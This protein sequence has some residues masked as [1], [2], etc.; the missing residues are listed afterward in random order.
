MIGK[1]LLQNADGQTFFLHN[2]ILAL[3]LLLHLKTHQL[4]LILQ[5]V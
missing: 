2:N 5:V 1:L 4:E 3:Y